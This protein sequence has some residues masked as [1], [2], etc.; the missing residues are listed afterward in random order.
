MHAVLDRIEE[1]CAVLYVGE[2]EE[3]VVFPARLLPRHAREGD[4]LA[5]DIRVDVERTRAAM[6]EASTLLKALKQ[7]DNT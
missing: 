5:I 3:K 4:Y 1:G 6:E 2:R 7:G